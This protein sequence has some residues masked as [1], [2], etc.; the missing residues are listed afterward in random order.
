MIPNGND[1]K[2]YYGKQMI[3]SYSSDIYDI[4]ICFLFAR[5]CGGVN[6]TKLLYI[7]RNEEKI[8]QRM[9]KN[10]LLSLFLLAYLCVCLFVFV[11]FCPVH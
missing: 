6:V 10:M 7:L 8:A 5:F 2:I 4:Y 3:K 9:T 1:Y 11:T